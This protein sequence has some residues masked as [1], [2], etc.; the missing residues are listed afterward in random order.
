MNRID[1][2]HAFGV[3]FAFASL[4]PLVGGLPYAWMIFTIPFAYFI[5][6]IPSIVGAA[7]F[8]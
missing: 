2:E 5:G 4:G 6:G 8:A 3:F 1:A 7:L